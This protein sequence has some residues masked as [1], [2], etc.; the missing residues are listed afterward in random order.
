M[1]NYA[2]AMPLLSGKT[3]AWKKYVKERSERHSDE[4]S[5]SHK[6]CGL[7]QEQVW[8]QKTPMGDFAVVC[9]EAENPKRVFQHFMSSNEPYDKWFREKIL[10]EC[11]GLK[12]GDPMPPIN[13][14]LFDSMSLVGEKIYAEGR[15]K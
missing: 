1:A 6:R 15:K 12:A 3:E 11:H 4:I 2:F 14:Q 9:W 8:L 10:M 7:S 5:E 13:E